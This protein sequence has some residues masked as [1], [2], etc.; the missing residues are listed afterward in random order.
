MFYLQGLAI[1]PLAI[2]TVLLTP[3]SIRSV[4]TNETI[5]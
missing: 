5:I 1:Q 2:S 4:D 3:F